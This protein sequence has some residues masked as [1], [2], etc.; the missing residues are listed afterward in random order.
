MVYSMPKPSLFKKQQGYYLTPRWG[1]DKGVH[2]FPNGIRHDRNLNLLT[3]RPQ[4]SPF[5]HYTMGAPSSNC[6]NTS[7]QERGGLLPG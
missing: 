1:G 2:T 3:S 5:S 6:A 7:L 4:S